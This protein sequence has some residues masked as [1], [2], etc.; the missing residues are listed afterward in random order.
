[1]DSDSFFDLIVSSSKESDLLCKEIPLTL[2]E[3][4]DPAKFV[5]DAIARVFPVDQRAVRLPPGDLGWVCVLLL[6]GLVFALPDLELGAERSPVTR[7]VKESQGESGCME[8]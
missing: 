4:I 1:M 8:V 2:K 5:M 7:I 6:E 3:S